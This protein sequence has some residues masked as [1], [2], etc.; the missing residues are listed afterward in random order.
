[1]DFRAM[2]GDGRAMPNTATTLDRADLRQDRRSTIPVFEIIVECELFS[3]IDWSI[4]GVQLDGVCE[5]VKIGSPVDGWITLPEVRKA[6]AFSG[7]ILRT[8]LATGNTVVRFDEIEAETVDF[9]DRA[10]AAR[11]H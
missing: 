1:M 11:L 7:R 9:L 3:S 6:F 10:V 4:G 8:D 2:P 5:G